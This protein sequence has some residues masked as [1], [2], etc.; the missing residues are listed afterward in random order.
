MNKFK[1]RETKLFN[2]VYDKLLITLIFKAV[3]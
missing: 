1:T 3:I 2:Y